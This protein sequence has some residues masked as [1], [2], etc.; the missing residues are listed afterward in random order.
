VVG[1][2]SELNLWMMTMLEF[3]FFL[4]NGIQNGMIQIV[5][6]YDIY[7]NIKLPIMSNYE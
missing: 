1:F 7:S 5:N 2:F 6:T 4:E 3:F